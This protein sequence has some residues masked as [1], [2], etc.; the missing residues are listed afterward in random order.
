M[1]TPRR[2][3]LGEAAKETFLWM[4]FRE[5]FI[6]EQRSPLPSISGNLCLPLSGARA[7]RTAFRSHKQAVAGPGVGVVNVSAVI[8]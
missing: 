1:A 4:R 2:W 6:D 8:I 7:L 5:D 3:A